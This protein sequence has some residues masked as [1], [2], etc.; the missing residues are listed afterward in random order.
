MYKNLALVCG[1]LT[2]GIVQAQQIPDLKLGKET[3]Q[4]HAFASQGFLDSDQNNFL[5]M[6][7][8]GGTFGMTDFGFNATMQINDKLRVGAQ[9]YDYNLGKL[10]EWHPDLDWAVTDYHWKD[11]LG[12]RAGKVKTPL[13][14]FN[15]TQDMEFLS[16]WALMPQSTYPM[17]LRGQFIA[18]YGGDVYGHIGVK[19]AGTLDYTLYA[20]EILNDAHGGYVR[21][22]YELQ[23]FTP[24]LTGVTNDTFTIGV[25]GGDL[26]WTT[27]VKGLMVGASLMVQDW[28][29]D[30]TERFG[31]FSLP[32]TVRLPK[33]NIQ[34]YYAQYTFGNLQL[35]AEYR[36]HLT[37]ANVLVGG[38]PIQAPGVG[39]V[40]DERDGF[41][42]AAYRINKRFEIGTYHSRYYYDLG[43]G[44]TAPDTHIFDQA[45]TLRT[46]LNAFLDLKIEQ[47]VMRGY[48]STSSFHGF[49][50]LENM[51][52]FKPDTNMFV[53]RL[54]FHI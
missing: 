6:G 3:I 13:G 17:D 11:W 12:V 30:Q 33:N 25:K 37:L 1:L 24:G 32:S 16:T 40:S 21:G 50:L 19:K 34:A 46:D 44:T 36:R 41:V 43:Q 47:H 14:L 7:T 27:P 35:N 42:S 53:V 2:A 26:R 49:Y 31:S 52:G 8:K 45:F 38:V 10:G 15:D 54:G 18:H 4:F 5:T 51:Q 20:G 22:I 29:L 23:A 39:T 28:T 48:G 9:I